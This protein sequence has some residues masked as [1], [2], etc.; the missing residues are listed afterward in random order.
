MSIQIPVAKPP[1]KGDGKNLESLVRKALNQYEMIEQDAIAVALSGGKD[2]LALLYMLHAV[3]GFGV[4]PFKLIAIHVAGAFSC[5]ANIEI[6]FLKAI[7]KELDIPLIIKQTASNEPPKECYPCSR[8]RR[9][10]LFEAAKEENIHTIAFGHH[11]DDIVNTLL[12]NLYQKGEFAAMLPKIHMHHYEINIIRPLMF[13]P[14]SKIIAFAKANKF[15]RITCQCPVG[16]HS[17][18]KKVDEL[19]K[20]TEKIFPNI[21]MNLM[22]SVLT[23]GSQKA[24]KKPKEKKKD[25]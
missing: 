18:R 11:R 14:E 7:C 8:E 21:R 5:G 12:L 2:S 24:N 16:Q 4:K 15:F 1:W 13:I 17:Q 3:N 9:K 25:A 19:I 6:P 20:E 10:L 23:Y 22:H